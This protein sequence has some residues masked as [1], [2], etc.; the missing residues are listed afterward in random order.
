MMLIIAGLDT[1]ANGA[2]LILHFLGT[3][4]D[5]RSS[6]RPTRKAC[7]RGRGTAQLGLP[8]PHHSRGVTQACEVGGHQFTPGDVVLLHWLA[9]KR[10]PR[11]YPSPIPSSRTGRLTA[12][13]PSAPASTGASGRTWQR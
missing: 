5:I 4:P 8:R 11:K 2:A 3:R 6:W 13:T 9:A 10:D 7:R 12:I 1:T